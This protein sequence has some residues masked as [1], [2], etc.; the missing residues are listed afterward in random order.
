M[1]QTEQ[2]TAV[3]LRPLGTRVLVR[4]LEAEDTLKGGIILP[5]SA[6]QKQ[7]QAEVVAVGTGKK[8]SKGNP[9]SCPVKVGDK[10][11]MEKYAGQDVTVDDQEYSILRWDDVIA[12]VE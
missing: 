11:L 12:I 8:D 1:T 6:K 4:R 7:E 10:I 2:K 5:D 9:I 3:K